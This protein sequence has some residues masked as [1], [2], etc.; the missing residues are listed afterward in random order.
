MRETLF[1]GAR[2]LGI[3][4]T[5]LAVRQFEAYARCLEEDNKKMNLT[6]VTGE[7]E[8]AE[9]HFLDSLAVL[10]AAGES[11]RGARVIDVGSG[12]GFPGV[13][14]KLAEPSI[15]LTA[16]DS[17]EKRVV[18]L[19][20][21]FNTL[22]ISGALAIFARAEELSREAEHRERYDLAVSRAVARLNVLTELCL[23]FVK[24][25][26]SFLAMKTAAS[27]EETDEAQA[28]ISLLGGELGEH[29]N[30]EIMGARHRIVRINKVAPTPEK[31]PRRYAKIL[32]QPL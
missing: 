17:T 7:R 6:A 5:D 9:R 20:K 2:R 30:Y 19:Q 16:L 21:I 24:V 22:E 28:A 8:I 32:K 15:S 4:L 12:P 14:M 25:G 10:A 3:E 18:F 29:Y 13:P 26:G 11:G 27:G 23:P 31:Y 1:A